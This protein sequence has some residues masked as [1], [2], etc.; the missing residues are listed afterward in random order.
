MTY[1]GKISYSPEGMVIDDDGNIYFSV[2]STIRKLSPD[3]VLT[4]VA[5][6]AGQPDIKLG[7]L[8]LLDSPCGLVMLD[9]K[10]I[11]LISR[12]AILKLSLP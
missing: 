11:A 3:G 9:S 7:N 1:G 12:N 6:V 10:T 5:G 4:I 8:G 2:D